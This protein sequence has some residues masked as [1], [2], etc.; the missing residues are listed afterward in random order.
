VAQV[1]KRLDPDGVRGLP[2][3]VSDLEVLCYALVARRDLRRAGRGVDDAMPGRLGDDVE[4]IQTPLP[5]E[6]SW[7]EAIDRAGKLFGVSIGGRARNAR[8]LRKLSERVRQE[9]ARAVAQRAVS[10]ADLLERRSP[11]GRSAAAPVNVTPR[12]V[13]ARRVVELFSLLDT[14]DA[15]MLATQ[16][17]SFE[18]A[19]ST[20]Q[21]MDK[22]ITSAEKVASVLDDDVLFGV[23]EEL[24]TSSVD[25]AS[26][27]DLAA[28]AQKALIADELT[29]ELAP[30][31][32]RIGVEA[33]RLRAPL[34]TSRSD[35][36]PAGGAIS[37]P[38]PP[39]P[40][41]TIAQR[42]GEGLAA[43]EASLAEARTAIQEAGPDAKL[44]FSWQVT[45]P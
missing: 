26:A 10:V 25:S 3:D 43:L 20:L 36:S 31:L 27:R 12:S 22:H 13:T 24:V 33:Q 23:L 40:G 2:S 39:A 45:K 1:K 9:R 18:V 15:V 7:Q 6:R 44:T 5:D 32:R 30:Q 35:L 19:P 14:H 8:N 34:A 17:G 16:L 4:L 11:I 29:I 38:A 21:A 41:S 42:Q 37:L 28:Q